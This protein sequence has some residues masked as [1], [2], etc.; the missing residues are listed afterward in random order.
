MSEYSNFVEQEHD[1]IL[2]DWQKYIV[3]IN[4][5][6]ESFGLPSRVFSD[7]EEKEFERQWVESRSV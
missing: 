7:N 5:V 2:C 4:K 1:N 3:E 6:R